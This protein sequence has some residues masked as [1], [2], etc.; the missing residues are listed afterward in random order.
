MKKLVI[1]VAA[2]AA[3]VTAG[4]ATVESIWTEVVP[5]TEEAVTTP[6]PDVVITEVVVEE[7]PAAE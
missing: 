6:L 1:V 4:C 3:L 5:N 2:V 7:A